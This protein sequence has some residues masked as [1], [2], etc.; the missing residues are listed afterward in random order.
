MQYEGTI[1]RP[2]SEARSLILQAT[3]GC[4]HNACTF[5]VSY[6]NK[7]YRVRGAEGIEKDLDLLPLST[8]NEVQRVFLADG[9]AL[10]M[11]TDELLESL[12]VLSG[13]LPALQ[14][15]GIYGYAKDVKG[16]SIQDLVSLREAGLGIIYLG[17]ETGDDELLR[18]S[19]K[20]VT[21]E[22]NIQS[23]RKIKDA[24]IPLSLTV[25]LGLGGKENS[26]RHAIATAQALNRI[27][28]EYVGA[29]TLMIPKGTPLHKL[30]IDGEFIPMEPFDVLEELR[31][32]IAHTALSS[33]IFRTNHAS[34]YLPLRGTLNHDKKKLLDTLDAALLQ[35]NEMD[36][37]PRYL[38]GL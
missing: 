18:W 36:L 33:C 23:C 16:K 10:A 5:C 8:K 21:S 34:N 25:I 17:L 31:A 7:K 12:E 37:R 38:R 14:R 26:N 24:G 20:G 27:D 13:G 29:L 28:P 6:K 15:V 22:E 4:S 1:W 35:R 3:V 2:P 19:R 9:N 32:M 30:T 11:D